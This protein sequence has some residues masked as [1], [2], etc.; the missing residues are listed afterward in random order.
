M[1][2]AGAAYRRTPGGRSVE[3]EQTKPYVAS[4]MTGLGG[5][6]QGEE[7]KRRAEPGRAGLNSPRGTERPEKRT[8]TCNEYLLSSS[9]LGLER[10]TCK[11]V[12]CSLRECP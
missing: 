10:L 2:R 8:G 12:I 9:F 1:P 6:K 3:R 4:G 5:G 7:N 11:V